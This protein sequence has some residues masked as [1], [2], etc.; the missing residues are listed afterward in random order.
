M[1]V[2][3]HGFWTDDD[4]HVFDPALSEAL[5]EEFYGGTV[6]DLGCGDGSYTRAMNL[7]GVDCLG[8]DGNPLLNDYGPDFHVADLAIPAQFPPRDWVL[9]LEVGEHVP[10]KFEDQLFANLHGANRDGMI[11]SW[12][13]EGQKGRAH[14]NCRNNDYIVAKVRAMGYTRDKVMQAELREVATVNW[15]RNTLMVFRKIGG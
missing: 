11:I 3:P 1:A 12:A 13:V 8:V 2:H 5:I 14:V 9:C 15:F 4:P 7:A 6:Y 10:A